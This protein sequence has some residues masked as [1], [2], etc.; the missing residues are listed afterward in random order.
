MSAIDDILYSPIDF[1]FDWKYLWENLNEYDRMQVQIVLD[2]LLHQ[3]KT[4]P[5][6]YPNRS[7]IDSVA[8]LTASFYPQLLAHHIVGV[9]PLKVPRATVSRIEYDAD[10]NDNIQVR[11]RTHAVQSKYKKLD[12]CFASDIHHDDTISSWITEMDQD[13]LRWLRSIPD[14]PTAANT[15]DYR[16]PPENIQDEFAALAVLIGRQASLIATRTK[17]TKGNWAIVSP[18]AL[19]IIQAAKSCAYWDDTK[20]PYAPIYQPPTFPKLSQYCGMLN[21][22]KLFCDP[23]ADDSTSVL[24]GYK[25]ENN[26]VDAGVIW[27]PYIAVDPCQKTDVNT[28]DTVNSFRTHYG[29]H[30]RVHDPIDHQNAGLTYSKNYFGVVGMA[31]FAT[32]FL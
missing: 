31:G 20:I 14:T 12:S 10:I 8:Q 22:V 16:A 15:Y 24:V 4:E 21:K 18:T 5:L 2:N 29:I 28:F 17:R 26:T 23:Y 1:G 19:T 27:S 6:L 30:E 7:T 13:L 25:N 3:T 9:Q 32:T 11:I